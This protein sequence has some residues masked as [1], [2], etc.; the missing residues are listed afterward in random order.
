M[1]GKGYAHILAITLNLLIGI[2]SSLLILRIR[3]MFLQKDNK[4]I[5]TIINYCYLKTSNI[6]GGSRRSIS[7]TSSILYMNVPVTALTSRLVNNEEL[8][9]SLWDF[10]VR[11]VSI[12][13][14]NS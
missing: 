6:E 5:C 4:K 13:A 1:N 14:N 10:N 8:N 2:P 7:T 11:P 9:I 3:L 12:R